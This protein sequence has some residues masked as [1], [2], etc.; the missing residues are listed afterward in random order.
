LNTNK[1]VKKTKRTFAQQQLFELEQP[2]SSAKD[3][4]KNITEQKSTEQNAPRRKFQVSNGYLLEFDQL[5]RILHFLLQHRDAK[6]ISSGSLQAETGF[7]ERQVETLVSMGVA[8]GLIIPNRQ[9]LSPIGTLIAT[10][11]I[12]IE[13]K[14]SL[15][16]CHYVGAGSYKNLIWYEIFNTLLVERA[17]ST[18]DEWTDRLRQDLVGK[19]SN[20]TMHKGLYEEIRFVVDAYTERNFNKLELLL[21]TIDGTL[22][23]RRYT[24]FNPHFFVAMIYDFCFKNETNLYQVHELA[25]S[26]GSPAMVFGV[27]VVSL[28]RLIEGFHE[29]GWLRYETTHNL[30]QIRLKEGFSTFEFLSA[31]YEEREPV[32]DI[33]LPTGDLG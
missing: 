21:K 4:I 1:P 3:K 2:N 32:E 7:V 9:I 27:D 19:Y 11:D 12:F 23:R 16:W 18:Q 33:K 14:S 15:E 8:M 5:A 24:Q 30:D 28:R 26:P 29:Q 22:Y 20:R 31:Y 17:E 6:K 10:H 25:E 13:Q